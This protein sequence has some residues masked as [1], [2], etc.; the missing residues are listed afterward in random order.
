M[1][2]NEYQKRA[3]LIWLGNN[4]VKHSYADVVGNFDNFANGEIIE[5]RIM[6]QFGMAGKIWNNDDRIYVSGW[7]RSEVSEEHFKETNKVVDKMNEELAELVEK[8]SD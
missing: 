5:W 4:E 8:W 2:L 6:S 1:K 7:S 3:L